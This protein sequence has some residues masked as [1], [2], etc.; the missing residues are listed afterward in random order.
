MF[1][2]E[3]L[4]RLLSVGLLGVLFM[5]VTAM[6]D[7]NENKEPE[8]LFTVVQHIEEAE[9]INNGQ[10]DV[11]NLTSIGERVELVNPTSAK[12]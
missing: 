1:S 8:N 4:F 12:K 6:A 2:N 5:S 11:L 3:G 9:K 10:Y 7:K